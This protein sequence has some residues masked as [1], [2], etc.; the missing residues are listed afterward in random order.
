[1]TAQSSSGA[2]LL[3]VDMVLSDSR[4]T[5]LETALAEEVLVLD[6]AR[7]VF[8]SEVAM[9]AKS[10]EGVAD[11]VADLVEALPPRGRA[12]GNEG[13][14]RVFDV[15]IEAGRGPRPGRFGIPRRALGRLDGVGLST[16]IPV[17]PADDA[18]APAKPS[19]RRT[20]PA[21]K[22]LA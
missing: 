5:E 19:L 3:H 9:R 17:Y 11:L 1:M 6:G 8:A 20:R 12:L 10:V 14:A 13:K 18:V 16:A 2:T 21:R 4:L 22:E 7:S 15:G